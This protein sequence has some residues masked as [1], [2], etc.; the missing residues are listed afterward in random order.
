MRIEKIELV[1]FKSF[2]DRTILNLHQ[3]ITCIVGPNGC[4]K[5]NIVDSFKWVL[6]EQ[7][8]KSLRGEKMEEVIFNGSQSKKPKGMAE[9]SLVVSGLNGGE[10]GD[11]A[12]T[13]ITRRLYRSGDSEYLINKNLC[14]LKDIKDLFLDTGLEVRSYSILE[15]DRISA[16]LNAKPEERRF[17]IE[18][19]AGVVKYKVRRAEAQAK[20]Q[21]SRINLQRVKDIIS[22][23]RRQINSLER[24]VKKAERYKKLLLE[25]KEIELR[26]TKQDYETSRQEIASL[27]SEQEA[28]K[29]QEASL[30]AELSKTESEIESK[31]LSLLDKEKELKEKLSALKD[32]EGLI[33]QTERSLAVLKTENQGLKEHLTRIEIE[34]ETSKGKLSE[35][36]SQKSELENKKDALHL[37]IE[38]LRETLREK[39]ES[40][41]A[42]EDELL[43][44]ETLLEQKRKEAFSASE[45]LSTIKNELKNRETLLEELSKKQDSIRVESDRCKD[46]ISKASVELESVEAEYKN[47]LE[48]LI[49]L[50]EEKKDKEQKIEELEEDIEREKA[51]LSAEREDL[52]SASSK[53]ESLKEML[54]DTEVEG[55]EALSTVSE[56]I[57][58][59][60]EYERAVEA[61]L[62]EAVNALILR[63]TE[64]V[65]RAATMIKEMGSKKAALISIDSVKRVPERETPQGVIGRASDLVKAKGEYL[66]L[67][68][69]ILCNIVIVNDLRTALEADNDLTYVTLDGDVV[70]PSGV[71]VAGKGR[72]LL[73]IKRQ[74]R[75]LT[76]EVE[77]IKNN[78]TL[79]QETIE[80]LFSSLESEENSLQEIE[81]SISEAERKIHEI[82]L[83]KNIISEE[84]MRLKKKTEMLLIEMESN[85][86]ETASIEKDIST[87]R[88]SL[89]E[90][91]GEKLSVEEEVLRVQEELRS[92][93]QSY[94]SEKESSV[95]IRVMLNSLKERADAHQREIFSITNTISEITARASR[96]AE[97]I[98]Q[99]HLKIDEKENE[100]IQKDASL[101]ELIQRTSEL[102]AS[103]SLRQDTM[104]EH[105]LE[106]RSLEDR[107]KT[108][109]TGLE[110]LIERL[111]AI[112]VSLTEQRLRA[113][114]LLE[115]T[116]TIYDVNIEELSV[117]PPLPNDEENKDALKQKIEELGPVSL[118]S[119]QEHEELKERYEF[120][121]SQEKDIE[122]SIAELEEAISKINSTTRK[123]LR[124]AYD[125]LNTKFSEVFSELFGGGRAEL[126]LTDENNILETGIEIV[127][128][129]PGKRLQ[130]INLLSGGEK[131]LTALALLFSSFLIKP[132]PLCIL[133]EADAALDETSTDKFTD[134]L[135]RLSNDTQFIII[136]HNKMTMEAADFLYGIT[137]EEPGVSKIISVE[138]AETATP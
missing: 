76:N 64:D 41:E 98:S 75:E 63:T 22:E 118:A 37:E 33:S 108:L 82:E 102:N 65:E 27:E 4:G 43:K 91:E 74:I 17:L 113:Q 105:S 136:T 89:K 79:R 48:G 19:V 78:I 45:K 47:L 97:E 77:K 11:S 72:E 68:K 122:Q 21:N 18:E 34:D 13:A 5:S 101:K 100:I 3:G 125:A 38:S 99:T 61:A 129:P 107:L 31:K 28:L 70:E 103:I 2:S 130:N 35:L 134:L 16:V 104:E 93:R 87:L 124:E 36:Q 52:V 92:E 53:I 137:M 110:P 112:D 128:Q 117:E 7:S 71:V 84:L 138:L 83:R 25:L 56:A 81:T 49:S 90:T 9:V 95:D 69:N 116:K 96:R 73:R 10:N 51:T 114:N 39:N 66:H 88:D 85:T 59:P 29:G 1:G 62:R 26:L 67:I 120:L 15:Q 109:R 30:R 40:L 12:L 54:L 46:E 115:N 55:I 32:L 135:R 126:R 57:E 6:G 20:L 132:T 127:A 111:H 14:R 8:A 94:E 86:L 106:I 119:L 24:Q 131:T 133:D 44:K 123:K 58:V 50:K 80:S 42:K 60:S 121:T 23:V